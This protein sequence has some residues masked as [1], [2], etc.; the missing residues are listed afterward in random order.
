M[1]KVNKR[2]DKP[3]LN[4]VI[5]SIRITNGRVRGIRKAHA[6]QT[7]ASMGNYL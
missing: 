4:Q 1:N 3:R 6:L 7:R 2:T 5:S